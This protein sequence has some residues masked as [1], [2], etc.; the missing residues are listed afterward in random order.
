MDA[1]NEAWTPSKTLT[2]LVDAIPSP[3]STYGS[4]LTEVLTTIGDIVKSEQGTI[5]D[6]P[7][8]GDSF[9]VIKGR[10]AWAVTRTALGDMAYLGGHFSMEFDVN[11]TLGCAPARLEALDLETQ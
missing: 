7:G 1:V 9:H 4:R 11:C 8:H 5:L 2:E 10:E 3:P 6:S